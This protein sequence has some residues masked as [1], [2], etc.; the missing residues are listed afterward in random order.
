LVVVSAIRSPEFNTTDNLIELALLLQQDISLT[1]LKIEEIK[2][3]HI[4]LLKE[5]I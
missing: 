1:Y 3:F 2:S 5:K 4:N